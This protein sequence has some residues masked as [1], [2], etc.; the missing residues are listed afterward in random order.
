MTN[1]WT[2]YKRD[3]WKIAA[4]AAVVSVLIYFIRFTKG[5]WPDNAAAAMTLSFISAFAVQFLYFAFYCVLAVFFFKTAKGSRL[6]LAKKYFYVP[7][8]MAVCGFAMSLITDYASLY[9]AT[10]KLQLT[11]GNFSVPYSLTPVP[12]Y[13][14]DGFIAVVILFV[15]L[16]AVCKNESW[17]R[18]FKTSWEKYG[19]LFLAF[20]WWEICLG[21][22][23]NV[24]AFSIPDFADFS[25]PA[26]T[27]FSTVIFRFIK[28]I[29][30]ILESLIIYFVFQKAGVSE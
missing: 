4:G 28:M 8:I 2:E 5:F 11:V 19:K 25:I 7:V 26:A 30:L 27:V 29:R 23:T 12:F 6:D 18:A 24:L 10:H 14:I 15:F 1:F 3:F 16:V 21:I 22:L 17:A 13:F 20:L 9:V